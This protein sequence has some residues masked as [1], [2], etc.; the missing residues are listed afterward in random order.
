MKGSSQAEHEPYPEESDIFR[1]DLSDEERL[2]IEKAEEHER[3]KERE[4][5]DEQEQ[6]ARDKAAEQ[7]RL[8]LERRVRKKAA[9]Q[10]QSEQDRI[11][12]EEAKPKPLEQEQIV[13][14]NNFV[15]PRKRKPS[16][17]MKGTL[18]EE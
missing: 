8:E 14:E 17:T 12:G 15:V 2:A 16:Q 3:N 13:A 11:G 7:E 1:E 18:E 9:K 10:E 5:A 4:I 6:M